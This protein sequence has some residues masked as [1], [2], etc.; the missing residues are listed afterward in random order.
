MTPDELSQQLRLSKG[1]FLTLRRDTVGLEL[2][3]VGSMGLIALYQVGII[4]HLPS[5]PLPLLDV[6]CVNA[7][8]EAYSR[9]SIP[10]GVLGLG[11]YTLTIGL[12]AMGGAHRAQKQPWIPLA[13]ACKVA[14]DAG[15]AIRL[16]IDQKT[17]YRFA[18]FITVLGFLCAFL[19]TKL[20]E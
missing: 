18:G 15:Q 4:K 19:L 12:A 2:V 17:K 5:P 10:D 9:F 11:N 7:S 20:G 16:F 14:F 1:T 8:A 3:A 13:S 6:D